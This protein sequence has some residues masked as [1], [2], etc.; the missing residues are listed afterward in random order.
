MLKCPGCGYLIPEAWDVCKK[1]GAETRVPVAVAATV[2]TAPPASPPPVVA[3]PSDELLPRNAAPAEPPLARVGVEGDVLPSRV[4]PPARSS[5]PPRGPRA[6]RTPRAPR[7]QL[8]KQ[9]PKLSGQSRRWVA[10]G[11]AAAV[12]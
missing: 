5:R 4:G 11:V 2:A 6:P 1:C 10:V 12:V 9:A 8:P 7:P 3:P